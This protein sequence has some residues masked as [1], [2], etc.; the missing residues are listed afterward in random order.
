MVLKLNSQ[1]K[2][3]KVRTSV[4]DRFGAGVGGRRGGPENRVTEDQE[5]GVALQA[6]DRVGE[7]FAFLA[8]RRR[9]ECYAV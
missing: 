4:D 7:R 8:A 3:M 9:L 5:V 2:Y 6:L 1:S